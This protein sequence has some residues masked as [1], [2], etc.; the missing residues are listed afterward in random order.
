M[1]KPIIAIDGPTGSGK[2]TVSKS[3]ARILNYTY[4]DTGAMYRV[5]ALEVKNRKINPDNDELLRETCEKCDFNFE[6]GR[7][8]Q[9]VFLSGNDVTEDIRIPEISLLASKISAKKVVRDTLLILQRKLGESGGVVVEG[10]DIGT[11]VFPHA[12]IKFFLEANP[13]VRA[14]RRFKELREK[15]IQVTYDET[16]IELNKR[17]IQDSNRELAPLKPAPDAIVIDSSNLQIEKVIDYMLNVVS[18]KINFER[19]F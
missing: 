8:G 19:R 4:M 6:E 18:K 11:V 12:D 7:N 14:K 2:T 15:G 13:E 5:L 10:R 3:L 16:L 9:K 1:T 17:D